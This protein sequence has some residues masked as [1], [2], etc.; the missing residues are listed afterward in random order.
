MEDMLDVIH[1]FF[2]T[3]TIGEKEMMD[4]K[5]DMRRMLYREFYDRTYTWGEG[6][7]TDDQ[8]GQQ[9]SDDRYYV[10]R[11]ASAS[12]TSTPGITHKPYIPPTPM[13]ADAPLP[14]GKALNAPLG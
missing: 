11:S 14:F 2:E 1:Y 13:N 3:D 7:I 10:G 8:W 9:A 12:S 5:R 4:A 6:S